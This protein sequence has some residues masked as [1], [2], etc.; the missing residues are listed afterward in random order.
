M[1]RKPS[2]AMVIYPLSVAATQTVNTTINW[3]ALA[4]SL[5]SFIATMAG[6]LTYIDRRSEKRQASVQKG[7]DDLRSEFRGSLD[8]LASILSERLETK[9]NVNQLR[10]EVARLNEQFRLLADRRTA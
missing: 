3:P 9:D 8:N 10:I 2:H 5:G 6:I 4:I 1:A 7:Q